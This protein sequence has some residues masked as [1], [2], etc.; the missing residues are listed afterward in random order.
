[1][2]HSAD[3]SFIRI[4]LLLILGLLPMTHPAHSPY[5]GLFCGLLPLWSLKVCVVCDSGALEQCVPLSLTPFTH[6]TSIL[7]PPM[8]SLLP[9]L[10]VQ[11]LTSN[12][13]ILISVFE[14]C[15]LL[16]YMPYA[17]WNKSDP[18]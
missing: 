14:Y 7:F 10:L 15:C 4:P 11:P 6:T 12:S 5:I 8:P 17:F 13:C 3:L 9:M 16:V 1:M 18:S 2:T